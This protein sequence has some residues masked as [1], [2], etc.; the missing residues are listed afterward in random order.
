MTTVLEAARSFA[1]LTT[2]ELEALYVVVGA[3]REPL[4]VDP[5]VPLRVRKGPLVETLRDAAASHDIE[6]LAI[7]TGCSRAGDRPGTLLQV[8]VDA[9][10]PLLGVPLNG[11]RGPL[12]RV[13]APL[14]GASESTEA[15]RG[16]LARMHDE[17]EVVVLHVCDAA[18][19]PAFLDQ[20]HH[21]L[22]AW[23]AE[24]LARHG[25]GAARAS[26][27]L[28]IGT[29]DEHI[30]GSGKAC[31]ADLIVLEWAQSLEPGKAA[32]VR[33]TLGRTRLPVLLLPTA[34]RPAA[35]IPLWQPSPS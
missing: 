31:G 34:G 18:G 19:A 3:D 9:R 4:A 33:R 24:F 21:E 35:A 17:V 14:D 28:R 1:H 6:C 5:G 23:T 32:V 25:P 29:P 2:A 8:A 12:R 13:L 7:G 11:T 27:Q 10:A 15:L 26:L 22:D 30:L 16:M 20:P